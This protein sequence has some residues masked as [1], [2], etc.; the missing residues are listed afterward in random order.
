MLISAAVSRS[1]DQPPTIEPLELD[2]PR[3]GEVVVR[4]VASGV[5]HTDL[6]APLMYPLPAVL[7]HEG[8]GV[9]E[10]VGAG[11]GKVKPGDRVVM[12]FGSCGACALCAQGSPAYCEHGHDLQFSG[13]RA[14]GS[15]TLRRGDERISG[16]FF[17]QSSFATHSLATERS[18]VR[19]HDAMPLELA[20]PLGC[21]IQTGAGAIFNNLR[22][23]AGSSVVVFGT[24]TVGLAA[25]MAARIAGAA[26]IVAVDVNPERLE[27]A[28]SLGAT[29]AIDAREG[30][31]AA[32]VRSLTRGGAMY[33]FDTAGQVDS[34]AAAID[35]LRRKG[36]CAIA[37]VPKMGEPYA[38]TLLPLLVGGKTLTS[39]L[40]GDSVPDVFIPLLAE[41]YLAGKLP[42]DRLTTDYPFT[43]IGR[44]LDDAHHAR[45]IKPVLRME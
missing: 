11:V 16:S 37:T 40:E 14:D 20:A 28:R 7:G 21:G 25:V 12:T 23:V 35:C 34:I 36:V 22:V 38:Q 17:Q 39:V 33:S 4:V 18:V 41:M 19:M 44:A 42:L 45:T 43:D 13:A 15:K 2:E 31:V 26:T 3:A 30:D 10:R 9:V 8:A 27:L 32:R 29:A 6:F 5:C 24:G 1:A